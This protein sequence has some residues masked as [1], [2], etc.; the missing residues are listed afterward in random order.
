[1]LSLVS[2]KREYR[3]ANLA[4]TWIRRT[5]EGLPPFSPAAP[6]IASVLHRLPP[7]RDN[8]SCLNLVYTNLI[9]P[10]FDSISLLLPLAAT[11][12]AARQP[13]RMFMLHN[14]IYIIH[15]VSSDSARMQWAEPKCSPVH[16]RC[17]LKASPGLKSMRNGIT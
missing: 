15:I 12:Q 11:G 3:K 2:G 8:L 17:L 1:M 5:R 4:R 9:S 10:P 13:G 7:F 6:I 16:P 14:F